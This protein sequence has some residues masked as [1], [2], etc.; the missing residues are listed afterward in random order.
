M[1]KS[2]KKGFTLVELVIVIAVIAILSA[3]LIPTFGNVIE[4]SK[5]TSAY[6]NARNAMTSYSVN[7]EGASIGDGWVVVFNSTQAYVEEGSTGA[8][9]TN[10]KI[11]YKDAYVFQYKDGQLVKEYKAE[12]SSKGEVLKGKLPTDTTFTMSKLDI[13]AD[14]WEANTTPVTA[15]PL[16]YK[17]TGT[18]A[19]GSPYG[20]TA[21]VW[22]F[23]G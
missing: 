13:T 14:T 7:N 5:T 10:K 19:T 4:N 11:S 17:F 6:E 3:V 18:G 9:D 21:T 15:I 22:W 12:G 16:N 23:K 2:L 8:N 1:K 20:V